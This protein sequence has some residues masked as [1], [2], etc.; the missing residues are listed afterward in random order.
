MVHITR[1]ANQRVRQRVGIPK[2]A[3]KRYVETAY[4]DGLS[5]G[6]LCGGLKRYIDGV[7]L[8]KRCAND[9]RVYGE[10]VF[11]FQNARLITITNLPNRYKRVA[12][13]QQREKEGIIGG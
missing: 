4:L 1:H 5:H 12:R 6:E 11:L 2:K 8:Q 13:E 10:F 9:I 3:V 7:Y